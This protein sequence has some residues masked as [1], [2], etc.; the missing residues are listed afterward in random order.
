MKRIMLIIV[1]ILLLTGCKKQVQEPIE[2]STLTL[3]LK[4]EQQVNYV[5][6][7]NDTKVKS[8]IMEKTWNDIKMPLKTGKYTIYYWNDDYYTNIYS[9]YQY[10]SNSN[11]T[12]TKELP[13]TKEKGQ[14]N[15]TLSQPLQPNTKQDIELIVEGTANKFSY[16]IYWSIGIASVEQSE[17]PSYCELGFWS[18]STEYGNFTG[19]DFYCD[20][21][22]AEC[23]TRVGN[24]CYAKEI[25]PPLGIYADKCFFIGKTL[26]NSQ[27]SIPLKIRTMDY[28]DSTDYLKVYIFDM[29]YTE[30]KRLFGKSWLNNYNEILLET[31][32][33]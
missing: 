12:I 31:D 20:G 33:R 24:S 13:L 32:L 2:E 1:L 19:D 3:R 5:I 30:S 14:I 4:P 11:T 26:D 15:A 28:F 9:D 8:G 25:Q 27:I 22:V 29:D 17:F 6:E 23:N 7:I 18:N 16:C 21:V 10:N